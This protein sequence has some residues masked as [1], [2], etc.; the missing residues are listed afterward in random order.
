[1]K[2]NKTP[3]V[4]AA[5]VKAGAQVNARDRNTRTPLHHAARFSK[6]PAVVKVLLDADAD[7]AAKDKKG[8]TPFDYAKENAALKDTEVLPAAARGAVQVGETQRI[9]PIFS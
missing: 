9:Y 7:P 8:R 6:T 5:L 2:F 3:A 1:M 4:A